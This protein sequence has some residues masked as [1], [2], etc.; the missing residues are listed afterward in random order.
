MTNITFPLCFSAQQLEVVTV[1]LLKPMSRLWGGKGNENKAACIRRIVQG[2]A[3]E[4]AVRAALSAL[5][6]ENRAALAILKE[7][8][9]AMQVGLL[10]DLLHA[11]GYA[12]AAASPRVSY[13]FMG[14]TSH[15]VAELLRGGYLLLTPRFESYSPYGNLRFGGLSKGEFVYT[16]ERFL[17][18]IDW[19][20]EVRPLSLA[21]A[22]YAPPA[23]NVRTPQHVTLDLLA[24]S[25]ALA[26][27]KQLSLTKTQSIRVADLRQFQKRL[28]WDE[29]QT[30]DG[31]PFP[32]ATHAVLSAWRHAGWLHADEEA[33][34]V[35]ITPELFAQQPLLTQVTLLVIGFISEADWSELPDVPSYTMPKIRPARYAFF[36][37]LRTLP[38]ARAYYS[39]P[40]FMAALYG[41]VGD[42]LVT[43]PDY[44]L[45]QPVKF[46]MS[47]SEYQQAMAAWREQ[48]RVRWVE[49]ET[50]FGE[51]VLTSWLYWLG[52]VEVGRLAN[53]TLAFRLTDLGRALFTR[54]TV[55]PP[56]KTP[57]D[58]PAWV[59]QPNYDIIVYLD[60]A[61]PAQ[62]AFLEQHAERRQTEAHTVHYQLTR[63]SVYRGLQSGTT[64][65][66]LLITLRRG[67]QADLPQNVERELREWADRRE[68]IT[69]ATRA[70]II[71]FSS[72]ETRALALEA[73]LR[74]TPV[75]E[76]YVRVEAGTQIKA[77]LKSVFEAQNIPTIDYAEKPAK[78][79]L[80]TE[81]GMLTL[82]NDTGDLLLRG[83]LARCT[84]PVDAT[85][86]RLTAA[87]LATVRSAGVSA[88]ALLAFLQSRM[89]GTV[90]ALLEI[91][92][93]NTLGTRDVVQG[94]TA[95]ILRIP[96]KKLH[97]AL[98]TSALLKPYLL[99][100]PGPDTMLVNLAKLDEF[101]A[102]L[103][104]LGVKLTVYTPVEK[105]PDWQQTVRDAKTQQR[106]RERY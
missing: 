33:L 72:P 103:D 37:G 80:A 83:Q 93:G 43:R 2:L 49:R 70:R 62:L 69:L 44:E 94:E 61:M 67:S 75:G 106:R 38:D 98:T 63:E 50:A 30:F 74:G 96:N 92:I 46:N 73:G 87:S 20:L 45:R 36:H 51:A 105:R 12:V 48:H 101:K 34:T 99:D 22:P 55:A 7:H 68:Q 89:H 16:D 81:D 24:V 78:C 21:P 13:G 25:R 1:D 53:K 41:R 27:S 31:Y 91:A 60:A 90:P 52:V 8:G 65:E 64:L 9:G 102:K 11:Y 85:H 14:E 10:D 15:A 39:V 97:T 35:A 5:T 84:E 100:V 59:M 104:W 71:E 57:S 23:P 17:Q 29:A 82:T 56:T 32:G 79:L 86:W 77:A 28:G 66:D 54:E 76:R 6:P 26:E 95:F 88:G 58:A 3:D 4:H 42:L 19:P 18:Q 47:E 40:D